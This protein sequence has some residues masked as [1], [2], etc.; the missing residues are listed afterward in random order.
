VSIR[1]MRKMLDFAQTGAGQEDCFA[2][3]DGALYYA[4]DES[5]VQALIQLVAENK[6]SQ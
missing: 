6:K 4:N 2:L 3:H 5:D 1:D